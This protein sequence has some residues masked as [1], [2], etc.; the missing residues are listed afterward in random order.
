MLKMLD[1]TQFR[2]NSV[3]LGITQ[4]NT[5]YGC[6]KLLKTAQ[7]ANTSY[8]WCEYKHIY[9]EHPDNLCLSNDAFHPKLQTKQDLPTKQFIILKT[10]ISMP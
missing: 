2:T 6:I 9:Q 8:D 4:M 3:F 7:S 10:A 1:A 5:D